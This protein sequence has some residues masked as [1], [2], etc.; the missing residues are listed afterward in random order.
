[1][2][3]KVSIEFNLPTQEQAKAVAQALQV[4]D[5]GYVKTSV[6]GSTIHAIAEAENPK[7]MMHTLDDYLACFGVAVKASSGRKD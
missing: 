2:R 5:D 7:S 3:C 4:D 6:M 1:M